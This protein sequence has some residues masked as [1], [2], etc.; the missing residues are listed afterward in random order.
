LK[1]IKYFLAVHVDIIQAFPCLLRVDVAD[2]SSSQELLTACV[3]VTG[4]HVSPKIRKNIFQ[5][6]FMK[7]SGILGQKLC[8]IREFCQF[9]FGHIS[10]KLGYSD[11]FSGKNHVKF[12]H[13]VIFFIHVF[14]AKMSCPQKVD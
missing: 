3:T 12:G 1:K 14:R 2:L 11:N 8:K 5:A 10:I 7:N 9:I 13:F 4:G 6:I